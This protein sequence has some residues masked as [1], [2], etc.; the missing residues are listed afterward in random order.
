MCCLLFYFSDIFVFLLDSHD[1]QV[2]TEV[3]LQYCSARWNV[4]LFIEHAFCLDQIIIP[5]FWFIFQQ[6]LFFSQD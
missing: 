1:R 3:H 2:D 4:K 5:I 6:Q